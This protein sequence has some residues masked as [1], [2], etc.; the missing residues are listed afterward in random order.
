MLDEASRL[1]N[2]E[3]IEKYPGSKRD[4]FR[5]LDEEASKWI[6]EKIQTQQINRTMEGA[7][8]NQTGNLHVL[9]LGS[10]K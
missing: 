7:T 5:V 10:Y 6:L 8:L 2:S 9:L 3:V 4:R 1:S